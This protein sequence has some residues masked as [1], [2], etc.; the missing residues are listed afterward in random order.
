MPTSMQNAYVAQPR[1]ALLRG[2]NVGT[3]KRVA[4]ADLRR[5]FAD[6]GC[7]DVRT[8]LNSGNV[9]FTSGPDG[10][11]LIARVESA[12][13]DQT[14][15][16][17]RVVVVTQNELKSALQRNPFAD[18]AANPSPLLMM[19]CRDVRAANLLKP[20]LERTWAPEA[21]TLRGRLAWLWCPAGIAAS[22]LW[23][24]A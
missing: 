16:S 12:I 15:V 4:M 23:A 5:V 19:W 1:A 8:I 6:L 21:L 17:T 3:A 24:A 11:D 13:A 20:L 22:Q 18:V 7:R 10:P 14:G 9:V 2:I